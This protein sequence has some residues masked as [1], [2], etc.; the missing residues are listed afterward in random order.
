[1]TA[2]LANRKQRIQVRQLPT[3]QRCA[4]VFFDFIDS[5]GINKPVAASVDFDLYFGINLES[6]GSPVVIEKT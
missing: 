2:T 4:F 3:L 6:T 5:M 1:L